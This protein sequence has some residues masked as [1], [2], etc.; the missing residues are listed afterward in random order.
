VLLRHLER[1]LH[2]IDALPGGERWSFGHPLVWEVTLAET[3]HGERKQKAIFLAD[4]WALNRSGEVETVARLYHD[5]MEPGRGIPWVRKALDIAIS[6]H[7]PET[8]ERYHRWLQDLLHVAGADPAVRMK[9][10]L[11]V[12]ERHMHE[13]GG[14]SALA[15]MLEF[16]TN[17]P[18]TIEERLPA[19]ILLADTLVGGDTRA[20]RAQMDIIDKEL[21]FVHGQLPL[22]WEA[23]REL[24]NIDLLNKQGKY[25]LA[26][27]KLRPLSQVVGGVPEPWV[28]AL[29]AYLRGY[30]CT[31]L[32][33]AAE[34][35]DALKELRTLNST[36]GT[37]LMD[38]LCPALEVAVA[39]V[40]GD[41]RSA[42]E[43]VSLVL[44][45]AKRRGDM[46]SVSVALAN[47]TMFS[48]L[49]G[50]FDEARK[51]LQENLKV[52][53]RFGFRDMSDAISTLESFI[54]WGEQKWT[55]LVPKLSEALSSTVGVQTG[56]VTAHSF[57]AEGLLRLGELPKARSCISKAEQRKEELSPGELANMLR[58]RACIE[59]AEGG[60]E[61]G[62]STLAEALRL[63][64]AHPNMYWGAWVKAE[65][66]RWESRHGDPTLASSFRAEADSLFDKSG[67][68]PS[69][70]QKWIQDASHLASAPSG[71]P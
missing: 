11:S 41:F 24:A 58:V 12:C 31:C 52:C 6:Q 48:S 5:A 47:V 28:K 30:C 68:V 57:L 25:T 43:G 14:G 35:K 32:G 7:A 3:D 69:A 4:W 55:E 17:L 16:L 40:D 64:E 21:P 63:L 51:H 22:K 10:G 62:R 61:S 37:S 13:T 71:K 45:A 29:V 65:T 67:V 50:E 39:E 56:R 15:H 26:L 46:R 33:L 1:D 34:A 54:L 70:K 8:V 18:V 19:R 23:I 9:E 20:A 2:I 49:R 27:E 60:H 44:A 38:I 66:A 36:S 53:N 59:D 42:E